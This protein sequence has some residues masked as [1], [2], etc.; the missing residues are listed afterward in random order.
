M[1]LDEIARLLG[2]IPAIIDGQNKLLDRLDRLAA[3]TPTPAEPALLTVRQYAQRAGLSMCSI[4]RHI[5]DGSLVATKIGGSIRLPAS[6][7][8]P[9]DPGTVARLAREGRS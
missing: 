3:A 2:L 5:K 7:L 4:R 1:N 8:R 6:S 9:A